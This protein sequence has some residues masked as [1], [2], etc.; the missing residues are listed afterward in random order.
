MTYADPGRRQELITGL[1]ALSDFLESNPAVPVPLCTDL[2]VFPPSGSDA[3]QRQ[4]IDVIASRID[5]ETETSPYRRHYM[6][7]RQLGPITYRAVAVPS[8]ET[9]DQ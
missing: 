4:E 3:E 7:S 8:D 9:K 2:L 1:R 6:T 5:S